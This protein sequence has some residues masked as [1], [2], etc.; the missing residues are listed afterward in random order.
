MTTATS[1]DYKRLEFT[2]SLDCTESSLFKNIT[3][4]DND[5][6][7]TIEFRRTNDVWRYTGVTERTWREWS[8][9][10]SF[11]SYYTHNIRG[12]FSS[13]FLGNINYFNWS[14]VESNRDLDAPVEQDDSVVEVQITAT[15]GVSP[16]SAWAR[17]QEISNIIGSDV[18]VR[19]VVSE[20]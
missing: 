9:A 12:E 6:S 5:D 15:F 13:E 7:V 18:E 20:R 11:G 19:F 14:W 16:E 1:T 10:D 8:E 2:D 17:F 4:N 3:R